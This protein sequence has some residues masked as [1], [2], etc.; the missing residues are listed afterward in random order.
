MKSNIRNTYALCD[1]K[2]PGVDVGVEGAQ[3]SA[4]LWWGLRPVGGHQRPQYSVVDLGV[5]DG[6]GQAVVGEPV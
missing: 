4:Q 6:E 1:G 5:E 2:E 3:S